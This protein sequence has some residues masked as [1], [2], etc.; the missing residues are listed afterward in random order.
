MLN[1]CSK[2]PQD[3]P[4]PVES[5]QK[6]LKM[7]ECK[8]PFGQKQFGTEEG[9]VSYVAADCQISAVAVASLPAGR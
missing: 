2:Q 6:A 7:K 5:S 4:P 9:F 8:P 3:L 1:L